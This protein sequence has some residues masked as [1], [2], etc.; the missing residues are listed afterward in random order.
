MLVSRLARGF[1]A[2]ISLVF[3]VASSAATAGSVAGLDFALDADTIDR[4][5]FDV[6]F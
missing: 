3:G 2:A 6:A 4:H 1:A 5:S